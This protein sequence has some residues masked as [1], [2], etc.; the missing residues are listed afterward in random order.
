[1]VKSNRSGQSAILTSEQFDALMEQMRPLG[2]AIFYTARNTAGRINEV[3]SLKWANIYDDCLVFPKA[4]TKKK[5]RT[6]EIPLNPKIQAE[7]SVWKTTWP[8]L[9]QREPTP[10]DYLFPM[11]GDFS[12]HVLRRYAD[13]LLRTACQKAG[14]SG[15]STHSMRRSALTAASDA[16]LPL[17]HIQELSGHSS[18]A[19]LQAYLQC[20]EQ[21]KRAVAMAFG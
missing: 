5:V 3:L 9:Y 8:E 2:R 4:I 14:I 17:R 12:R 13:R 10:G 7:L 18:L 20:S 16:G 6:R 15:C 21:Q 19:V 11:K 1:M